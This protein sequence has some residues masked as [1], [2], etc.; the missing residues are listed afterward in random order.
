LQRIGKCEKFSYFCVISHNNLH[1]VLS[2]VQISYWNKNCLIIRLIE[3]DFSF[4]TGFEEVKHMW[5]KPFHFT[6]LRIGPTIFMGFIFIILC[7]SFLLS[8]ETKPGFGIKQRFKYQGHSWLMQKKPI[9]KCQIPNSDYIV[10]GWNDLG[11]HC[12]TPSYKKVAILPPF[13]NL[14]AQVIK[15]GDPPRIVTSGITLEY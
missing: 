12:I 1:I 4:I 6:K 3:G 13:N 14:C 8:A 5:L 9:D 10:I 7:D 11:M 2:F 15:R